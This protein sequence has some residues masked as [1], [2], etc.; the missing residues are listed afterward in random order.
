MNVISE[1][2]MQSVIMAL[3]YQIE[4][5]KRGVIKDYLLIEVCILNKQTRYKLNPY[6]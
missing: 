2:I 3:V 5:C 4:S 1:M 6:I